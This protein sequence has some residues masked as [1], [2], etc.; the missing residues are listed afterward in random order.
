[1]RVPVSGLALLPV[2]RRQRGWNPYSARRHANVRDALIASIALTHRAMIATRNVPD[3]GDFAIRVVN[4]WPPSEGQGVM[5]SDGGF[6][7]TLYDSVRSSA[8]G[9]SQ[10]SIAEFAP[11]LR[12]PSNR[13]IARSFTVRR[14]LETQ[15]QVTSYR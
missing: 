2:G 11:N 12:H 13:G 8:T 7:W 1:V 15:A 10:V 5:F 4:P 6:R 14:S 9:W 3:L